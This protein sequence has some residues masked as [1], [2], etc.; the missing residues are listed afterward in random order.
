MKAAAQEKLMLDGRMRHA[1]ERGEFGLAYQPIVSLADSR[2]K[3][4]E[5]LVR[6]NDPVRGVILPGHFITL[7]E[8]TGFI[9][10]LSSW[11]LDTAFSQMA[12]WLAEGLPIDTM[13]I[14]LG[15]RHFK[16]KGFIQELKDLLEKH[17]VPAK[18]ITLE[19]T[20]TMA[21]Q[22]ESDV[23]ARLAELRDLGFM[24]AL[25][26]FGTGH[27]SLSVLRYLPIH[28]L[29]ID[30]SF[31]SGVLSDPIAHSVTASIISLAKSLGLGV[32]AEGIE[33]EGQLELMKS[34]GCDFAQGYLLGRPMSA[35]QIIAAVSPRQQLHKAV[36]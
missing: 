12:A 3:G 25:D 27:S 11:I 23:K 33:W 18:C 6:W 5:A 19:I 10:P 34:L 24:I 28:E 36:A 8:E 26:D 9:E 2:I 30:R 13:A 15:F 1:L 32:I 14:N 35:S 29:K 21:M 17:D 20:E 16:S 7:A 22:D 31:L 4:V